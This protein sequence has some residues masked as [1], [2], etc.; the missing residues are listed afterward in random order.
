MESSAR[1]TQEGQENVQGDQN[2]EPA[3]EEHEDEAGLVLIVL[4]GGR[5]QREVEVWCTIEKAYSSYWIIQL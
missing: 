5:M 3:A 4:L 1:S 2:W